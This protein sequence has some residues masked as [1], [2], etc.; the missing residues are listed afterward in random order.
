M[1]DI[2][3]GFPSDSLPYTDSYDY[4]SDSDLE[5]DEPQKPQLE[6]DHNPDVRT[7][8][9]SPEIPHPGSQTATKVENYRMSALDFIRLSCFSG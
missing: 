6:D 3:D 8:A 9:K 1:R 5:D 2:N 7:L 4:L